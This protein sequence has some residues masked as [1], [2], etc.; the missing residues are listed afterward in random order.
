MKS[1]LGIVAI[2]A[3]ASVIA[4]Y[5]ERPITLVVA[6]APGGI[7]DQAARAV[8]TELSA[9]LGQTVVIEN[10][11][12]AG[13]NLAAV[14]VAKASPDGYTLLVTTTSV[15]VNPAL[16]QQAGYDL[17]R[18]LLPVGGIAA[19]ANAIV[20][21]PGAGVKTLPQAIEKAKTAQFSFGSPGNGSTSHLTGEYLFNTVSK[22]NVVHA[23]YRG[24]AL[25]V[26]DAVGGQIEF[27]VA[28]IPVVQQHVK[29]G[30]LIALAVTGEKR[31]GPWPDVSTVS[32]SLVEGYQD[33]TWVGVFAPQGTSPA[34][35]DRLNKEINEVLAQP[36]VEARLLTA[37]L[38]P[39][40]SNLTDFTK[41]VDDEADKWKKVI[42]ETGV[43]LD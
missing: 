2:A 23:A 27:A 36:A 7:A 9:T 39:R 11:G 38:E 18:D 29:A 28:P 3:S 15:A 41:F 35:I 13:G 14:Q 37:G 42:A 4:A 25:A 20:A 19:S 33:E 34:I 10:K 22:A 8:V 5:P 32:E 24:G 6:F 16:Y 1:A 21:T 17:K 43:K 31:Y 30:T 40:S 12:G 26:A